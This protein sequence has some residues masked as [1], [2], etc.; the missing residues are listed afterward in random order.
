[1]QQKGLI[2]STEVLGLQRVFDCPE[3]SEKLNLPLSAPLIHL[4]RLRKADNEP[5]VVLDTYLPY[6]LFEGLMGED[7]IH[8]S[9]YPVLER[10]YNTVVERVHR[11]IE[12]VNATEK[13]AELLHI[14]VG[15]AVCLVKT[16]AFTIAGRPVEYSIARYRGDRNQ[17]SI[18]LYRE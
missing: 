1:M 16:T 12:A 9:L 3:A 2:P 13:D 17:F 14:A 8:N 6:Q 5:I 7:F 15:A 11:Q 4:K 18:E 10:R